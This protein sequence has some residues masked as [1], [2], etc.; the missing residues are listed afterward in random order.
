MNWTPGKHSRVCSRHFVDGAPT[1][2]NPDPTVDIGYEPKPQK[3][4]L[5]PT[6]RDQRKLHPKKCNR[7]QPTASTASPTDAAVTPSEQ[8]ASAEPTSTATVD[9]CYATNDTLRSPC[10]SCLSKDTYIA[11]LK[12]QIA[13]LERRLCETAYDL[14]QSHSVDV[15][16]QF[17]TSDKLVKQNTGLGSVSMLNSL[18]SFLHKRA[19]KM[20]YWSGTRRSGMGRHRKFRGSPR[21]S[22]VRRRLSVKAEFVLVLMKLKLALPNHFLGSLF[23][24]SAASCSSICNTWFRF[25]ATELKALV[26]WPD[27]ESVNAM[28]PKS[29]R[30]KYPNLRCT[31]DCSETFIQRPRDLY[32]QASTWSD[33][34]H[35]NTVKYLVAIT[36]DGHISFISNSWGGRA[37]DRF[38]VQ[39]SGL[40]NLIDP[41]DVI[42]ADRGFSIQDDLLFRQATLVIPPPGSCKTQMTRDNVKKTRQIANS[43][44]H[45]ERAIN[46]LKWFRILSYTLPISLVPVFDDILL[47]CAALCNLMPPLVK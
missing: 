11:Q 44:I 33:Y 47:I 3:R 37:T 21:K 8:S 36:P 39:Q 10:E 9:H 4:R 12:Q 18:C 29:L 34:K 1:A 16:E 26:F 22:G 42:L 7:T 15:C 6:P 20:R 23:H 45:V 46:R 19:T 25:L 35:H 17:I 32:L 31:L 43:R 27:K 38:I 30:T 40:L 28:I 5:P 13:V 2:A 41:G 14:K 24:I